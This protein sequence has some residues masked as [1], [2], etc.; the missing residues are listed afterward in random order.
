MSEYSEK[1]L[2]ITQQDLSRTDLWPAWP[3]ILAEHSINI[4]IDTQLTV[5]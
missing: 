3:P 5:G 2:V 4:L 1:S